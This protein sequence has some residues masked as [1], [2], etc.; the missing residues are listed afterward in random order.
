MLKYQWIYKFS[1]MCFKIRRIEK[2]G[3]NEFSSTIKELK[4]R[5]LNHEY[6]LKKLISGDVINMDN[7]N[8]KINLNVKKIQP[9]K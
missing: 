8:F 3:Q 6:I 2:I 1:K 5:E 7:I 9:K 4:L